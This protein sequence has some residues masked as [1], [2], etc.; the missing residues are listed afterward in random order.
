MLPSADAV[1]RAGRAGGR[2]AGT[3]PAGSQP[4][5]GTVQ[6]PVL[7]ADLGIDHDDEVVGGTVRREE[8]AVKVAGM[9]VQPD[10]WPASRVAAMC[11]VFQSTP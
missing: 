3:L 2:L 11:P 5:P 9:I 8:A 1:L 7:Q 6:V 10:E 4:P